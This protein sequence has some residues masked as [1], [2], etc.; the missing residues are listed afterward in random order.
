MAPS[1]AVPSRDEKFQAHTVL[2][3]DKEK[4]AS[5]FTM[6]ADRK[7]RIGLTV[8][9]E[10]KN[11]KL[12]LVSVRTEVDKL[13]GG[14]VLWQTSSPGEDRSKGFR[15]QTW[16]GQIGFGFE[17]ETCT[18]K[19]YTK[20]LEAARSSLAQEKEGK[21]KEEGD[22]MLKSMGTFGNWGTPV[23]TPN[24]HS[25][26]WGN[27]TSI[28]GSVCETAG[29]ISGVT[30]E[31]C[32]S[33]RKRKLALIVVEPVDHSGNFQII[34]VV[35]IK[36][37][38]SKIKE[39]Q[40]L[41]LDGAKALITKSRPDPRT[42]DSLGLWVYPGSYV[43][44]ITMDDS[45]LDIRSINAEVDPVA[46]RDSCI[47]YARPSDAKMVPGAV[48]S[49]KKFLGNF[50]FGFIFEAETRKIPVQG[51]ALRQ[52]SDKVWRLGG[53]SATAKVMSEDLSTFGSTGHDLG[54]IE[55][56]EIQGGNNLK[57]GR[58]VVAPFFKTI[59]AALYDRPA[60]LSPKLTILRVFLNRGKGIHFDDLCVLCD[61]VRDTVRTLDLT[62][63]SMVGKIASLDITGMPEMVGP[64]GANANRM[65]T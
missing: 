10:D 14:S 31:H 43:G 61:A 19:D 33:S 54:F 11:E 44:L 34:A 2:F 13:C 6:Y 40:V 7:T 3:L 42:G 17:Y 50:A 25:R 12:G 37:Y 45:K 1:S 27:F 21:T 46:A 60:N 52:V 26:G 30:V 28:L 5:V 64:A 41:V 9:S 20:Q 23:W 8:R 58:A 36:E 65:R 56:I 35:P 47:F 18:E 62:S 51:K 22:Q 59:A 15:L 57:G 48:L 53:P 55:E 39:A 63:S 16:K 49:T 4:F 24:Q 32:Q 29:V 38:T